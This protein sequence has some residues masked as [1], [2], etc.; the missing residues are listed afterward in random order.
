MSLPRMRMEMDKSVVGLDG[1]FNGIY[2]KIRVWGWLLYLFAVW[3]F[4]INQKY[5]SIN[6]LLP[7]DS[8]V[9]IDSVQL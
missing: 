8:Q 1:N 7:S 6:H 5:F 9:C 2:F 4:H 3:L